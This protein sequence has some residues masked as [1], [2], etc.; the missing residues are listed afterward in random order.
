MRTVPS[1]LAA[2][3]TITLVAASASPALADA[4][5]DRDTR[6]AIKERDDRD[7]RDDRD[8]GDDG[9]D[10]REDRGK[11]SREES[12]LGW[13]RHGNEKWLLRNDDISV[14]FH[15]GGNGKAK[16][17]LRVFHTDADG[18]VSGYSIEIR[19]VLEI[20]PASHEEDDAEEDDGGEDDHDGL[21]DGMRKFRSMNLARKDDWNV[22]VAETNTTL[23]LTMVR[24]EA[25]GIVTL[26]FHIGKSSPSVKFDFKVDNWQWADNATGHKLALVL[27]AHE[28]EFRNA[29]PWNATLGG[30]FVSWASTATVTYGNVSRVANVTSVAGSEE[31]HGR[32]ALVFE[33][34][35][36]FDA[37]DYDP[38]LGIASA[39]SRERP[40]PAAPL[41]LAVAAF[42]LVAASR[43]RA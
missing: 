1:L 25:Q 24:A 7:D 28:R 18:N 3:L 30:G 26:V 42:A 32:L 27:V 22:N 35:G 39:S 31:G 13:G 37:L 23:T 5:R 15:A 2:L 20:G 34:P 21:L 16:P 17:A 43:R 38:T 40:V 9:D 10:R 29:G 6:D 11:G 14:W 33:A 8:G 4:G 36:G 19:R 12:R 41:A